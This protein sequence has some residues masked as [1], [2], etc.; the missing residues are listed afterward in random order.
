MR[1]KF[2]QLC[3]RLLSDSNP[4]EPSTQENCRRWRLG[5]PEGFFDYVLKKAVG[6]SDSVEPEP[7]ERENRSP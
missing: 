6:Y 3:L 4:L 7:F 1:A 5:H 2:F